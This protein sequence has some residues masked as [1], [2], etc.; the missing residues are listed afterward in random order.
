[1]IKINILNFILFLQVL[2]ILPNESM[3][4]GINLGPGAFITNTGA[5]TIQI[6]DGGFINN[7]TYVKDLE[8]ITFSG[9]SAQTILGSSNTEVYNLSITNTGGISSQIGLLTVHDLTIASG[10]RFTIDTSGSVTVNNTLINNEGVSGLVINSARTSNGSLLQGTSGISATEQRFMTKGRWHIISIPVSGQTISSFLQNVPNSIGF[11]STTSEYGM[12]PYNPSANEWA[13]FYT[14]ATPGDFNIGE[15]YMVRRKNSGSDGV[16]TATGTLQ[17]GDV[18][19]TGLIPGKWNCIGNPY[20]SSIG[21]KTGSTAVNFLSSNATQFEPNYAAIYVWN[22]QAGYTGPARN[23]YEVISNN[24][25]FP[26][27]SKNYLQVGQGFLVRLAD[28]VTS[29]DFTSTM[30]SHQVTETYLKKSSGSWPGFELVATST[31]FSNSTIITFNENMTNGLDPTYDAGVLKGNP[32]LAL[33]TRLVEDNGIDFAIQCLP[34]DGLID[35]FIIPVGVDFPSGGELRFSAKTE[36]IPNGSSLFLEDRLLGTF[37]DLASNVYGYTINLPS[38]TSGTGRFF[39]HM[40]F[41]QSSNI[42]AVNDPLQVY[43][44]GKK[45]YINGEINPKTLISLYSI[46]GKLIKTYSSSGTR[47]EQLDAGGLA[48]GIYILKISG[49]KK[50][51]TFKLFL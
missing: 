31:G 49:Q 11:N 13:A 19:V 28:A 36:L 51:N 23:D 14:A 44:S 30:Q 45:I 33:Y 48:D 7:G 22:E 29:V 10:S 18:S 12:M 17:A 38:A 34:L 27:L 41:A 26:E 9:T 1:M 3:G 42:P 5:S 40:A 37:T 35:I 2:L 20:P 21:V 8:T 50:N 39:L 46:Q 43:A 32:N 25:Y 4:Q 24:G 6:T 47:N 16:V 15:G